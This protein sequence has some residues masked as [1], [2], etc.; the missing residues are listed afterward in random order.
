M[1]QIMKRKYYT[2]DFSKMKKFIPIIRYHHI[3][4]ENFHLQSTACAVHNQQKYYIRKLT[5]KK[6]FKLIFPLNI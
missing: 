3:I 5:K 4:A 6:T 2:F 1:L